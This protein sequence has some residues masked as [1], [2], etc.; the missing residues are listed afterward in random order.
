MTP[1]S[2]HTLTNRPI[3]I[4]SDKKIRV[5]MPGQDTGFKITLDGQVSLELES[6]D[7]VELAASDKHI[8]LITSKHTAY[9][10]ILRS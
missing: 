4:S 8:N 6:G 7:A 10:E 3:L 5:E 9:Y 2:P 1:I